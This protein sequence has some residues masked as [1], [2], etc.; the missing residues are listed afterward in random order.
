MPTYGINEVT[1]LAIK[2]SDGNI[3]MKFDGYQSPKLNSVTFNYAL[4]REQKLNPNNIK[5]VIFNPPATIVIFKDDTKVVA[6][7]HNEEYDEE[8]GFMACMMQV[9]FHSRSQFNKMI[10]NG[11]EESYGVKEDE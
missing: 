8:K 6:K 7:T 3:V 1:S 9:M 11:I 10:D 4:S 5:K 2:D